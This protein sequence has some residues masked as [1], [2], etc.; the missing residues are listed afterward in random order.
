[1]HFHGI[2]MW[3]TFA[4]MVFATLNAI[5]LLPDHFDSRDNRK[6]YLQFARATT[7]V[8]WYLLITGLVIHF[9]ALFSTGLHH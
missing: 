7:V 5:S 4:T 8:A 6:S 9:W 3:F 2:S 1:M